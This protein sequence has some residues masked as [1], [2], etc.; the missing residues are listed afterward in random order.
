M[1]THGWDKFEQNLK[2]LSKFIYLNLVPLSRKNNN[3]TYLA[4]AVAPA[5]IIKTWL[6]PIPGVTTFFYWSF[7]F[8]GIIYK[9]YWTDIGGNFFNVNPEDGEGVGV[10][11]SRNPFDWKGFGEG[12]SLY[13]KNDPGPEHDRW[14]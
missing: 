4:A 8:G 10:A 3:W 5:A 2:P 9:N 12:W 1:N 13:N 14:K 6:Q 7:A 11:G